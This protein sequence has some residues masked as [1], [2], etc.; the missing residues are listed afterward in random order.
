MATPNV[1]IE[2]IVAQMQGIEAGSGAQYR[3][4]AGDL[5]GII[6]SSNAEMEAARNAIQA[7]TVT[8]A[9]AKRARDLETVKLITEA[10]KQLGINLN[11]D[12]SEIVQLSTAL[13]QRQQQLLGLGDKMSSLQQQD[14]VS[15]PL[16]WL[17][18][19]VELGFVE[20]DYARVRAQTD[21][22]AK[23]MNDR[24]EAGKDATQTI[25]QTQSVMTDAEAQAALDIASKSAVLANHEAKIK[26]SVM[27]TQAL[28]EVYQADRS[29][30]DQMIKLYQ[31]KAEDAA[32]RRASILD[33]IQLEAAKLRLQEAKADSR[34]RQ[35]YENIVRTVAINLGQDPRKVS[36]T[37]V[38]I[39]E[40]MPG[41]ADAI[42]PYLATGT[43]GMGPYTAYVN[44]TLAGGGLY[45]AGYRQRSREWVEETVKELE[46]RAASGELGTDKKPIQIPKD[47]TQRAIFYDKYLRDQA[48]K[49]MYGNKADK[50]RLSEMYPMQV[51]GQSNLIGKNNKFYREVL[52]KINSDVSN[53][54]TGEQ[55][56]KLA[57]STVES[58]LMTSAELAADISDLYK[59]HVAAVNRSIG[60]NLLDLP[61]MKNYVIHLP[62][63]GLFGKRWAIEN[64]DMTNP[65]MVK[66]VLD[67]EAILAKTPKPF[68]LRPMH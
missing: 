13:N 52:S 4:Q 37:P 40:K 48:M 3:K 62:Q 65:G 33:G 43:I 8:Q 38:T 21:S 47:P 49:D 19:Q 41:L 6:Q 31:L 29:G 63:G 24:F 17:F 45:N 30:V 54:M 66:K 14:F 16:Q 58:G 57:S 44:A 51:Y 25:L 27:G 68:P 11:D 23:L 60:S 7:A 42:P 50:S 56:M 59:V 12:S 46:A 28:A 53:R 1:S 39:L 2:S 5:S 36:Q 35:Q 26:A 18:N 10:N 67:R 55:L 34:N 61:Q 9:E 64:V 22:I 15:N 20:E 32:R